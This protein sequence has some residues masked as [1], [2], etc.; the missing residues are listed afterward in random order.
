M[1]AV[2]FAEADQ[3]AA[4]GISSC[5]TSVGTRACMVGLSKARAAP[6]MKTVTRIA[7]LVTRPV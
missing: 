4:R 7:S 1:L 5:G 6:V 2:W 3:A